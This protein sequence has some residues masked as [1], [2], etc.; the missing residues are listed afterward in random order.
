MAIPFESLNYDIAAD[1]GHFVDEFTVLREMAINL[2][3][4]FMAI[5][6]IFISFFFGI[7]WTFLSA[8]LATI[9]IGLLKKQ[10]LEL[11]RINNST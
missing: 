9:F 10:D 11:F 8:A 4:G 1:Q 3:K 6:L 2:G 5:L 7:Q